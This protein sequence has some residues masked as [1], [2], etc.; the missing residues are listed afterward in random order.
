M[1]EWMKAAEKV[2][3]EPGVVMILGAPSSGKTTFATFLANHCLEAGHRTAV[4]DADVGQSDIGPPCTIGLGF[5][6]APVERMREIPLAAGY[7]VGSTSPDGHLHYMVAGVRRMVDKALSLGATVVLIDTTGTVSGRFGRELKTAKFDAVRPRYLVGLEKEGEVEHLLKPLGSSADCC[8]V[9]LP[10]SPRAKPRSREER[11]QA[12]ERAYARYLQPGREVVLGLGDV[13]FHRGF[14]GTGRR[15]THESLK[16]ISSLLGEEVVHAEVIAE[17]LYVV[18]R[19]VRVPDPG[20]LVEAYG[21]REAVLVREASFADI[22]VGLAD[23]CG[24]LLGVGILRGIDFAAG[25]ARLWLPVA[26]GDPGRIRGM[27]M[28]S[29]RLT[30]EGR[31]LGWVRASERSLL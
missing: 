17:G 2:V 16:E 22:L 15:L 13:T 24:E 10:V 14:L 9:R 27:I 28:G 4:V 19:W 23:A 8:V 30:P 12:R 1:K 3:R 6:D 25:K 7:F 18:G 29:I 31:E 11:R 20:K 21:T 26:C 5:P